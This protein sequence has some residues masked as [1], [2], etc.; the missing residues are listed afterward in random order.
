ALKFIKTDLKKGDV[1][2]TMGA[3]DVYKIGGNFVNSK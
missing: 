1:L 2:L 3:G